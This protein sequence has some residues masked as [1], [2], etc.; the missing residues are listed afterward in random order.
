M[1]WM[2]TKLTDA[3]RVAQ[4]KEI[5]PGVMA[6]PWERGECPKGKAFPTRWTWRPANGE[7]IEDGEPEGACLCKHCNSSEDD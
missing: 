7:T 1:S 2:S 4:A 5:K 6:S 3:E